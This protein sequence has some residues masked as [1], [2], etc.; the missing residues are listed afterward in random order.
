MPAK[1]NLEAYVSKQDFPDFGPRA[2]PMGPGPW[3]GPMGP[4]L[5][6]FVFKKNSPGNLHPEKYMSRPKFGSILVNFRTISN[7]SSKGPGQGRA[8]ARAGP[9][10]GPGQGQGSHCSVHQMFTSEARVSPLVD[11]NFI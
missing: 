6:P 4:G 1:F 5:G 7:I 2:R 3:A 8:R 11:I 9:G 10:P